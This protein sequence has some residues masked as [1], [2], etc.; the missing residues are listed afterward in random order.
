MK[1]I[2]SFILSAIMLVT[3]CLSLFACGEGQNNPPADEKATY[4]VTVVDEDGNPVKGAMVNFTVKGGSVFPMPTDAEGKVS[5]TTDKQVTV[6]M[7]SVP[8]GYEYYELGQNLALDANGNAT[9]TVQKAEVIEDYFVILVV[10]QYGAP[11]EGVFVQMCTES[12]CMTPT[13]TDENGEASYS[14]ADGE[15]KAKLTSVPEGYTVADP[16]AYYEFE[17]GTATIVLTKTN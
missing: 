10:D 16:E 5:Y 2:L 4:T 3:L 12:S 17:N 15:F 7:L 11:V 9:V 1:K 6:S 8:D 14:Y 13:T